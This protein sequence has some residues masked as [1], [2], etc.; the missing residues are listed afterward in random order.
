M[1]KNKNT[2]TRGSLGFRRSGLTCSPSAHAVAIGSVNSQE[3]WS[4]WSTTLRP[5]ARQ[6]TGS[7]CHGTWLLLL[8]WMEYKNQGFLRGRE[9]GGSSKSASPSAVSGM[10]AAERM[11]KRWQVIYSL[12]RGQIFTFTDGWWNKS[13]CSLTNLCLRRLMFAA[14]ARGMWSLQSDAILIR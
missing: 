4:E 2:V 8:P 5:W 10:G 14:Q 11:W 6:G 13:E 1:N 12:H 7:N 3:T 9:V